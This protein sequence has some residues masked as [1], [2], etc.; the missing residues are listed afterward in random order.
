DID[1]FLG[2]VNPRFFIL[3]DRWIHSL[4][5]TIF[6]GMLPTYCKQLSASNYLIHGRESI[7]VKFVNWSTFI[8][9]NREIS[10][11]EYLEFLRSQNLDAEIIRLANDCVTFVK[12]KDEGV[13]N[14]VC[15]LNQDQQKSLSMINSIISAK[16][17]KLLRLYNQRQSM[18]YFEYI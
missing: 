16:Q 6:L 10:S 4:F 13:I 11:S 5:D 18:P 7:G 12:E 3:R 14:A 1:K 9:L 2:D 8:A 15:L 17:A